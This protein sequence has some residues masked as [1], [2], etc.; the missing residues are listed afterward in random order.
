M[1][2]RA[3]VGVATTIGSMVVMRMIVVPVIVVPVIV[4][5]VV[6]MR[7]VVIPVV[8]RLERRALAEGKADRAGHV[9]QRD[10][11]RVARKRVERPLEPGRQ[12]VAHPEHEVGAFQRRGFGRAQC[13][14]MRRCAM[15]DHLVG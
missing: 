15:L 5:R 12:V 7:V 9:E 10:G 11:G 2:V 1:R 4:M 3:F 6:V 14:F 8:M 13:V